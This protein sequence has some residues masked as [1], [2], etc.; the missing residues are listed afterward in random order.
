[1]YM[2]FD[3]SDKGETFLL[4]IPFILLIIVALEALRVCLH[5]V[6]LTV[7]CAGPNI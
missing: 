1:M 4:D 6:M 2:T 3:L 5:L 7:I